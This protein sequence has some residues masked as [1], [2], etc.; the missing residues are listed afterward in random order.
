MDRRFLTDPPADGEPPTYSQAVAIG[1]FV[2]VSGQIAPDHP[3]WPA[4]GGS[5]EAETEACLDL[6][7]RRLAALGASLSDVVKVTIFTT[8]LDDADAM[9]RAYGRRFPPDRRPAR[10]CVEVRQLFA[11][12][13]I[14]IECWAVRP[15]REPARVH[16]RT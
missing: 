2:F 8:S 3:D 5:F 12:A 13:R 1:D 7:D 16:T 15:G 10:T 11:A 4:E 9:E 14:E 6:C